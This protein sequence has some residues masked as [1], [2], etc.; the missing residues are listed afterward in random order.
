MFI[1]NIIKVA[2]KRIKQA[3]T[4]NEISIGA[5]IGAAI[6]FVLGV[7]CYLADISLKI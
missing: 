1:T 5:F 2:M 7:L 4:N 6:A 3:S